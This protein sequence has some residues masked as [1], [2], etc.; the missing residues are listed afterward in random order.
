VPIIGGGRLSGRAGRYTMGLISI[1]SDD[2]PTVAAQATTFNVMRLKRDVFGRSNIGA[3]ITHRSNAVAGN[4]SNAVY[5]VDG[6]FA[7][8]F[9]NVNT[10]LAKSQTPAL[11]GHDLSYRAQLDYNADRY[12]LELER[13]V[14]EDNFNPEVGF[15]RREDFRRNYARARFSPRPKQVRLIRKYTYEGSFEYDTDNANDLQSRYTRG[16]FKLDFQ[17]GD[18]VSIEHMQT[19][20]RIDRPFIISES[21]NLVVPVGT[22]EFGNTIAQYTLGAQHRLAGTATFESGTFYGGYKKT[23]GLTGR[24]EVTVPFAIEP[25]ISFNWLD[26]PQGR[27]LA[28]LVSTRATYTMTTRMYMSALIQYSSTTTALTSSVRFRWEYIP[29]SELFV[30]YSEGRDT[31]PIHGTALENRGFVVKVNRLLR[32]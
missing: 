12:G 14:V 21:D 28:K 25:T 32:F 5:G 11:Q 31:F 16:I 2:E 9:L 24:L 20:E 8:G 17:S 4:G 7:H 27:A 22:Y 19:L 30:V 3:L 1:R 6:Q 10:Y 15:M 18:S 29:G 13:L 26:L 23:A